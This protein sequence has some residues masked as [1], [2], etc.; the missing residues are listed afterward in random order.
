V[1]RDL[2]QLVS[3]ERVVRRR[4]P[5]EFGGH[6]LFVS[7]DSS[8]RFWRPG[9]RGADPLLLQLAGELVGPGATVW[10]VGANVGL[11]AFAAAY[12]SGPGGEVVAVEADDWLTCLLRRSARTL[13]A[14]YAP[15]RVVTAAV[16]EAP[17]IA[18]LCVARRGRAASHLRDVAG[19][20]QAG[21]TRAFAHVAA[22]SLDTL[23][24][25]F[26]PPQLL[27]IDVEG[28]EARCLRGAERLLAEVRP[29]LLC[30]VAAVNAA[31]TTDILCRHRYTIFDAAAAPEARAPLDS[32]PWN[33]LALPQ[34]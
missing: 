27:K 10:D 2:I 8:L 28:A 31:V 5:Q 17:G 12:R 23:L 4:L 3:Q 14:R 34:P 25:T 20:S 15:V 7:P 21:G 29:A 9:L 19:S 33:T 13:P 16:S 11:F 26:S 18:E 24:A 22:V 1:L 30:E 6:A 32:A